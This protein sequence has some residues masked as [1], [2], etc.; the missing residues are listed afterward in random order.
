MLPADDRWRGQ[1]VELLRTMSA[2]LV[3]LQA[4]DGLWRAN[5]LKPDEIPNPEASGS[6]FFTYAMAWGVNNGFL[7]GA[8]YLP[9]IARA[10]RGLRGLVRTDGHLGWVQPVAALPA[11]TTAESTAPFGVGAFLLAGS[12][13]AR[14]ADQG[15][16][17]VISS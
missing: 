13:V 14:I 12:E 6:G 7:D 11:A 4:P 8:T 2:A 10:W 1:Y 15:F 9:V 16:V 5:L 17:R 3:P